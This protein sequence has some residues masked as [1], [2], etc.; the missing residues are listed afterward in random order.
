ML[1]LVLKSSGGTKLTL[2][3]MLN[4]VKKS[5]YE[6]FNF[7]FSVINNRGIYLHIYTHTPAVLDI[8]PGSCPHSKQVLYHRTTLT[9]LDKSEK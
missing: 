4:Y 3:S 2:C 1:I 6:I 7:H 9:T 5:I 8:Q